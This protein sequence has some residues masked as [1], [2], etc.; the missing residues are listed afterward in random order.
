MREIARTDYVITSRFHGI[1][2]PY[3]LA[4]PVL[5][6]SYNSKMRNLMALSEQEE[7]CKDIRTFEV[8]SCTSAFDRM[9]ANRESI[10]ALLRAKRQINR[11]LLEAQYD[12]IWGLPS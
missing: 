2:L 6:L 10:T 1:L 3:L 4:K 9:V 12:L 8:D 5:A 11:K 7:Y